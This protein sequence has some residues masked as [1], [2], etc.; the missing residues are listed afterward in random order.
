MNSK[1]W[2]A[3]AGLALAGAIFAATLTK[4][5]EPKRPYV[6]A[7]IPFDR[8]TAEDANRY[9]AACEKDKG[10][11]ADTELIESP[12][13]TLVFYGCAPKEMLEKRDADNLKKA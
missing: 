6:Q 12:Y 10:M 5:Q 2:V 13:G 3:V 9:K 7:L 1:Y 11:Q 4:A 8:A